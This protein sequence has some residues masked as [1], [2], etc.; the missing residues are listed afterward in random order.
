MQGFFLLMEIEISAIFV[1][2]IILFIINSVKYLI[3]KCM[4]FLPIL[5]QI[6]ELC[7]Y[8]L[9]GSTEATCTE[10][11]TFDTNTILPTC[12]EV[13]CPFPAQ[14]EHMITTSYPPTEDGIYKP[15][16]EIEYECEDGKDT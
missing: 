6:L 11:E 8:K 15:N 3:L 2:L 14:R 1:I 13:K 9:S 4:S 12:V 16:T 5:N 7:R 10:A